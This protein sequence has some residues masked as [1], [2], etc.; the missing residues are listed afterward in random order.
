MPTSTEKLVSGEEQVTTSV[1]PRRTKKRTSTVATTPTAE[2]TTTLT[3]EEIVTT[4]TNK[5]RWTKRTTPSLKKRKHVRVNKTGQFSADI[6]DDLTIVCAMSSLSE[7]VKKF[8]N[9]FKNFIC[10][11]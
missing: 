2:E 10:L 11:T 4:S 1:K 7:N 8:F 6:G 9:F 3:S 5:I